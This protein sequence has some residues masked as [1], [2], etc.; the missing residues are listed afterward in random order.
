MSNVDSSDVNDV[1]EQVFYEKV[2][3]AD[4]Y[5]QAQQYY[6]AAVAR[7]L[8]D[9]VFEELATDIGQANAFKHV[10]RELADR[11]DAGRIRVPEALR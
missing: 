5:A 10:L 4:A 1:P 6:A 9:V 3:D 11:I 8:G 7:W 2:L